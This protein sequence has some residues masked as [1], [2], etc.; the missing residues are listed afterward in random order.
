MKSVLN[1]FAV[2]VG[3]IS[4]YGQSNYEAIRN[5]VYNGDYMNAAAL[6]PAAVRENPKNESMLI[7]C[8]DI[9]LELDKLDSA[10]IMYRKA[11]GVNSDE[12]PT[13]R[14]IGR[15]LSL[16]GHHFEAIKILKDAVKEAP[17]DVYNYLELGRAYIEADSMKLAEFNIAK[18]RE[19]NKTIPDAYVALGDL[20][21]AQKVYELAKNNYEEAL[22][23]NE[24]LIDAR[25][26][27]ATAYYWLG[28]REFDKDLA[29]GFFERSLKEWNT[30]TKKDPKNA[31]AYFEQGKILYFSQQYENAAKSLYEYV[32][33]RPSGS[34]GRWYLAQSLYEL[35]ACDSASVQLKICANEIDSIKS[36]ALMLAA[37]CYYDNS[38][39][40]ESIEA[41]L[42][43]KKTDTLELQDLKRIAQSALQIGDTT[44]A[45]QYYV[46]AKDRDPSQCKFIFDVGRFIMYVVK[47]YNLAITFFKTRLANCN[48]SLNQTDDYFIGY[49]YSILKQYD[50]AYVYLKAS[51]AL[52]PKDLKSHLFLGDVYA[53]MKKPDSA[54]VEFEF[55]IENVNG[56]IEPVKYELTQALFKLCGM[57]LEQ[58]KSNELKKFAQKW[59]DLMP[60]SPYGYLY[61]AVSYQLNG[62]M[63]NACKYYKKVLSVDSKNPQAKEMLSKLKCP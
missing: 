3:I 62:D 24:D 61:I 38:R 34:L 25:I 27:L 44:L 52:N 30:I 15:T 49:G 5:Y 26:K 11:D 1:I 39:Y 12:P 20:Y 55:I 56:N 59:I 22:S 31:R 18:A 60:D 28:M 21:F 16:M 23:I 53:G 63:E 58:K 17:E 36:K 6:I 32:T 10:L 57:F 47:D 9:Y 51:L 2:V 40:K 37:R 43:L 50:S 46:E 29:N 33:L 19:I 13:M 48:D 54:K 7:L 42:E 4:L 45:V 8:G 35:R 14:K 41:F